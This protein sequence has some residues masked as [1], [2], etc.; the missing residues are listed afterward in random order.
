MAVVKTT[1]T[2]DITLVDDSMYEYVYKINNPKDGVTLSEV[3]TAY[4]DVITAGLLYSK[5]AS[6]ITA[7]ARAAT[8]QIR[9]TT[10]ELE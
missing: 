4:T 9:T 6:P 7:V 8:V 10:T 2:L 5:N 3:R 1:S